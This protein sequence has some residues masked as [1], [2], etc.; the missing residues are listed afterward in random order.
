VVSL[1]ALTSSGA[2]ATGPA[3]TA[4]PK[5]AGTASEGQTLT[6]DPGTWTETGAIT[7]AYAWQRCNA[8]GA[9]CAPIP[10]AT[11][12]AY[13][14]VGADAG[15]TLRVAVSATDTT[16]STNAT[17]VPTAVVAHAA[18]ATGCPAGTGT[19]DV[20]AVSPPARLVIDQYQVTPVPITLSTDSVTVRFHVANTCGQ[21]VQGALVQAT[22]VPYNQ[23]SIAPEQATGADGW[24]QLQLHRLSGFPAA[25][26][27]QLLVLFARARKPGEKLLTGIAARRLVSTPVK[28]R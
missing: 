18:P 26:R 2:A 15:A 7:Y 22:S 24:A 11:G 21:A 23:F 6:A 20:A 14:V 3:N 19:A 27:Q 16:G 9:S 13:N 12:K 25:R 1:T 17:S 4:P 5:I 10:G 28:L 8:T